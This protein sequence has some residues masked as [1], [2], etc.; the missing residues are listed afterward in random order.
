MV[1]ALGRAARPLVPGRSIPAVEAN[2]RG[3]ARAGDDRLDEVLRLGLRRV[4]DHVGEAPTLEEREC[5]G[6]V[7][8]VEPAPVTELEQQLVSRKLLVRPLDVLE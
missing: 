4:D 7:L 8:L 5:L 2:V 6:P 3:R 1:E